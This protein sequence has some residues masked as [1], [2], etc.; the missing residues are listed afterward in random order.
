VSQKPAKNFGGADQSA[1]IDTTKPT[2]R[3]HGLLVPE[4]PVWQPTSLPVEAADG[5]DFF[6]PL[7]LRNTPEAVEKTLA[8]FRPPVLNYRRTKPT[9][10]NPKL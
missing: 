10:I 7:P 3:M 6:T 1:L 2:D 8:S 5:R 4:P 9:K